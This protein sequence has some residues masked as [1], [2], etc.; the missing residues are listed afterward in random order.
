MNFSYSDEKEWKLFQKKL[1]GC[2]KCSV[3]TRSLER[4][5]DNHIENEVKKDEE[6]KQSTKYIFKCEPCQYTWSRNK[7]VI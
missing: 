3:L 2:K 6:A 1:S 7:Q 4:G 5:I